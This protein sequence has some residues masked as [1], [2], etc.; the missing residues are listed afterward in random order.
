MSIMPREKVLSKP[1]MK[2][3]I[4][5]IEQ[6]VREV[7]P[8]GDFTEREHQTPPAFPEGSPTTSAS[9]HDL[10]RCRPPKRW[11]ARGREGLWT[12]TR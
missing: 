4:A 3:A 11:H 6:A 12:A 1:E 10:A 2:N 5:K 9:S 7:L 8:G